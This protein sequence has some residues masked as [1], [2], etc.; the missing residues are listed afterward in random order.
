M[1][2]LLKVLKTTLKV[3]LWTFAAVLVVLILA[4]A[5]TP[6]WVGPLATKLANK[7][8]PQYTGTDFHVE[9]IRLNPFTGHLVVQQ[10]HLANPAGYAKPEAFSVA[11]VDVSVAM[12]PLVTSGAKNIDVRHVIVRGLRASYMSLNGT[13]NFDR[14]L[15]N[16]THAKAQELA[17]QK[18]EELKT[19]KMTSEE[20]KA[21]EAKLEKEAEEELAR[22]QAQAAIDATNATT[23]VVIDLVDVADSEIFL[24]TRLGAIPIPLPSV[25]L[26]DIG[27]ES[28]GASLAEV[29]N[30]ICTGCMKGATSIGSG[31]SDAASAT[32]GA[33]GNAAGQATD[34][35]EKGAGAVIDSIGGLFGG[36]KSGKK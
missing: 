24:G 18:A 16:A 1:K 4:I 6:L 34:A 10:C 33:V 13:N 27:K 12:W 7:M 35:V 22:K 9:A 31:V 25:T 15:E 28:G 20:R 19:S 29:W 26:H 21:Y 17:A 11:T 3:I 2:K 8:A 23:K 30:A 14:I 36:K 32:A 5:T